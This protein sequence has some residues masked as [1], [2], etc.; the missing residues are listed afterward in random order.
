MPP[1]KRDQAYLWDMLDAAQAVQR[2]VEGSYPNLKPACS[3]WFWAV[4]AGMALG[5]VVASPFALGRF[6]GPW[7][8]L[9]AIV[10]AD[11]ARRARL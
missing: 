7:M 1:E 2:F 10:E 5:V 9:W 4:I 6:V 3:M 11:H 8:F